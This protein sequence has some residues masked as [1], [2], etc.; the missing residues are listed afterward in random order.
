MDT[1]PNA[2]CEVII[3]SLRFSRRD[4][5]YVTVSGYPFAGRTKAKTS[6]DA[7]IQQGILPQKKKTMPLCP[8]FAYQGA[9][10]KDLE[11]HYSAE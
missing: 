11:P 8:L 2:N 9:N 10:R 7:A 6:S 1:E 4:P 5:L 3:T